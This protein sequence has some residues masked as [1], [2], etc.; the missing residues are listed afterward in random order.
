MPCHMFAMLPL[1]HDDIDAIDADMLL[2]N[3]S[4]IISFFD[5]TLSFSLRRFFSFIVDAADFLISSSSRRRRHC[6][7]SAAATSHF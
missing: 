1:R 7:F 2:D 6:L 4:P 3:I 5:I